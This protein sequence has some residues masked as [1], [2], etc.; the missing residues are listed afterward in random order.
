MKAETLLQA[1]KYFGPEKLEEFHTVTVKIISDREPLLQSEL[2]KVRC[3][4]TLIHC[5]R[6]I[7]CP[8]EY[9]E[10]LSTLL[11]DADVDVDVI[12][13]A[14]APRFGNVTRSDE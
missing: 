7:T 6:D 4:V 11:L 14:D 2:R 8:L 5:A 1:V 13:I 10:E 9:V 12:Q 3:P